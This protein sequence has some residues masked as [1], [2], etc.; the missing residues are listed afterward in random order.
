MLQAAAMTEKTGRSNLVLPPHREVWSSPPGG[1][2]KGGPVETRLPLTLPRVFPK[3]PLIWGEIRQSPLSL[4]RRGRMSPLDRRL[5]PPLSK[6]KYLGLFQ[7]VVS[8]RQTHSAP[9]KA[10]R[11]EK[12]QK[13]RAKGAPFLLRD[14]SRRLQGLAPATLS[15][16][17]SLPLVCRHRRQ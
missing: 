17:L 2:R 12:R 10:K 4:P 14:S 13:K 8:P 1:R 11:M 7:D 16:T 6:M 3:W 9:K 15:P 5:S